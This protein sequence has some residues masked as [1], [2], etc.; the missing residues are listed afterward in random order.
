MKHVRAWTGAILIVAAGAGW[1]IYRSGAS[2]VAP[3]LPLPVSD[4]QNSVP[5][6]EY[7]GSQACAA[8]HPAEDRTYR[9]TA[10]SR[11]LGDIDLKHE[12][13]DGE[14]THAPS[15]RSYRIYRKDGKLRQREF[16][17]QGN[18]ELLLSDFAMRYVIGSGRFS[19]SY[20]VEDQG[21][22]VESPVTWYASRPGWAISPGYDKYNHGFERAA[23]IRCIN[24]HAGRVASIDG[25][26]HKLAI[27]DLTI[28]CERCH[29]P[30]ALHAARWKGVASSSGEMDLSIVHPGRLDRAKQEA[31]CSDCHLHGAAAV[32]IRGRGVTSFRP[33]LP[34]QEFRVDYGFDTANRSME[35]VGH[36]LQMRMSRCY[37]ASGTLTCTTCHNPHAKPAPHEAQAFYRRQCL[38]CHTEESCKQPVHE[39]T[40]KAAGDNCMT[41]HMPQV[42]TEIP[43]FAFTHH[44]IGLHNAGETQPEP[45]EPGTLVPLDDLSHLPQVDQ[46]RCLGLAYIELLDKADPRFAPVYQVRARKLLEGVRE[47]G[48]QDGDV[49]AGLARL[50]WQLDASKSIQHAEAA[51]KDG[52]LSAGGRSTA[53]FV[54]ARSRMERKE[55][56]QA[57]AVIQDLVRINR[58]SDAWKMLSV[59]Q[60]HAG[61]MPAA[62]A[63]IRRAAEISPQRPDFQERIAELLQRAGDNAQAAAAL[64]R[65]RKLA[66]V[67]SQ[68]AR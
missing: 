29:G 7:V 62:L 6:A 49:E 31:I 60:E 47:S 68:D 12:P 4:F 11:A 42:P 58:Y 51:L 18:D 59:C 43:H 1:L 28:G 56:A 65:A 16:A 52:A 3:V 24:C 67:G 10:H 61:D 40:A 14:F 45:T 50:Y 55:Y 13:P 64:E 38:A 57:E 23:E 15:G 66:A 33:G 19:R 17:R 9:E 20:L 44:R 36:M 53:L 30:G 21:F 8:C 25:S 32:T 5:S 63:S 46:D 35:V 26:P 48:L 39:R 2:S 22:L 34:L 41:C 27:S 37:Q 54:L